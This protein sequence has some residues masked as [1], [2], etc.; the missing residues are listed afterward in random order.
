MRHPT[1]TADAAAAA[2]GRR[3]RRLSIAHSCQLLLL[4]LLLLLFRLVSIPRQY[5][6]DEGLGTRNGRGRTGR[7][8]TTGQCAQSAG[9]R[10]D[11]REVNARANAAMCSGSPHAGLAL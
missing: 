3:H 5:L 8:R 11:G 6:H 4:L 9:M 1:H 7:H 10:H 2:T